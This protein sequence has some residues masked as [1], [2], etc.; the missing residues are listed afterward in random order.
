MTL[1]AQA[2]ARTVFAG[3]ARTQTTAID[4]CYQV[5]VNPVYSAG[6]PVTFGA[7]LQGL[8][9]ERHLDTANWAFLDG[10]VKAMRICNILALNT[11]GDGYR[12]FTPQDD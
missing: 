1:F 4:F 2:V 10:H 11:T 12:Y 6:P 3:D 7:T 5:T 8:F 9:V